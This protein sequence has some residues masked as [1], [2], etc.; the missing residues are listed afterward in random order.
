MH[1]TA[2]DGFERMLPPLPYGPGGL[3]V[4]DVGGADV[5]GTV[6]DVLRR[7]YDVDR[8]DVM[9]IAPGSGVTIVADAADPDTWDLLYRERSASRDGLYDLVIS[10][11]TLEHVQEWRS[12]VRGVVRVLR[13]GG[14]FV[15]T[16]ASTGRR[17]HGARGEH[18][19]PRGEWYGNVEP[20]ELVDHL[21]ARFG[22]DVVVEYSR[23]PEYP[24]TNDLY[25]R[26]QVIR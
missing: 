6:H 3:R 16:C 18:F 17:L 10:T 8:L 9:D 12:I 5:N 24:T 15:G 20:S 14:W 7:E 2:L 21:L 1:P 25:W 13:P 11:E 4:L 23:R 19:P 26:A 22:G